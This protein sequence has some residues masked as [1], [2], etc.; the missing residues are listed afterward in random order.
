MVEELELLL[1]L[2]LPPL[3]ISLPFVSLDFISSP[4]MLRTSTAPSFSA[5]RWMVSSRPYSLMR[6][7]CS[8]LASQMLRTIR[9]RFR[10]TTALL[11]WSFRR[12]R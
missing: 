4:A 7:P 3:M 11:D 1:G 12:M 2:R 6:A 5:S 8:S 10:R 9:S